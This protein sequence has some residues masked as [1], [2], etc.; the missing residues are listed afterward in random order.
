MRVLQSA[1]AKRIIARVVLVV[2]CLAM[3][4]PAEVIPASAKTADDKASEF[5]LDSYASYLTQKG[6]LI[7]HDTEIVIDSSHITRME[8]ATIQ[9]DYAGYDRPVVLTEET[10]FA[11]WTFD[12]SVTGYYSVRLDYYAI[13]GNRQSVERSLYIDGELPFFEARSL[14]FSRRFVDQAVETHDGHEAMPVQDELPGWQ[15]GYARDMMGYHGDRLY[16]YMTAGSHTIRLASVRE[17]MAVGRI[18]LSG[19]SGEA[20]SYEQYIKQHKDAGAKEISGC[21]EN[22]VIILEAEDAAWKSDPTLYPVSDRTSPATTPYSGARARL[23][24]IGGQKW[25]AYGQR[26]SWVL[27]VPQ[28]GLYTIALRSRQNITRGFYTNR[29]LYIDGEIP[30]QEASCLH[31]NYSESWR[32]NTLG[33]DSE[34]LFYLEEGQCV[35]TLEVTLGDLAPVVAEV[36]GSVN[37]LNTA[38]WDLVSLMG[39]KPDV[40]RNYRIA[41]VMPDVLDIFRQE[42]TRLRGLSDRFRRQTGQTDSYTAPLTQMARQLERMAAKESAIASGLT[43]FSDNIGALANFI[44]STNIQPLQLDRIFLCE[45]GASLP[46]AEAS[47]WERLVHETK[48]LINTFFDDYNSLSV[49]D[50]KRQTIRVWIG[51]GITGGRDQA[52]VLRRLVTNDFMS[53]H[54][55]DVNLQLIPPG[56]LLS[57]TL[58]GRGPDVSLQ[59]GGGDPVNY[60]MRGA[61]RDL[62][63]FPDFEDV[64]NRFSPGTLVPYNYLDGVYALP[65]T[66]SFYMM[67]YR[68]DILHNLGIDVAKLKTWQDIIEIIPDLQNNHYTMGLPMDIN[69]YAMFLFQSG[70]SFY[71]GG[72]LASALDSRE[73]TEAFKL[74]SEFFTNYKLPV[75]YNFENRFRF[76]SMPLAIADYTMINLLSISAPEIHGLWGIAPVPGMADGDTVNNTVAVSG[77]GAVMMANTRYP[78]ASWEFMKWWTS[79]EVQVSFGLEL[80]SVMGSAARY[81]TAN[82]A[83]IN[84]LPWTAADRRMLMEQLNMSRGI[85]EVPGGYYTTRYVDFA[86]RDVTNNNRE[87]RKTM[88]SYIRYIN[89]EIDIKRREF[90]LS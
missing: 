3:I 4:G 29:R 41:S 9:N 58:A 33:G 71:T 51:N 46:K 53:N 22:G 82:L 73:A 24:T 60:A 45:P 87:P 16:L 66:Q 56:T 50:G 61:V 36:Q 14:L 69:A 38:Y 52:Q 31:F 32:L 70:G 90:G 10:G 72:G 23:N 35:L 54:S 40:N 79:S 83:A 44:T 39:L 37:R 47:W 1:S 21:L 18:F 19:K 81:N 25:S 76:G 78:D 59:T 20:L 48:L 42:A 67:F 27:G 64:A 62:R 5:D 15:N 26:I 6:P 55:V 13:A 84:Q 74:W 11:E 8:D 88:M 28:T 49:G 43:Q 75:E 85:P 77:A 57:A 89:E 12:V 30:F 63:Q 34:Y 7:F 68:K 65:E 17:P 2:L 86:I 80:E